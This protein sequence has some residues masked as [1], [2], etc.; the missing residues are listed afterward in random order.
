MQL[1]K[2]NIPTPPLTPREML[3]GT[4]LRMGAIFDGLFK[5]QQPWVTKP[6]TSDPEKWKP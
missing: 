6:V 5:S 4:I 2:R 1:A 3:E